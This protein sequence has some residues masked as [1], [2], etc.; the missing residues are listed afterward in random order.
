MPELELL[1]LTEMT[2]VTR[3]V[4]LGVPHIKTKNCTT[5]TAPKVPQNK[6]DKRTQM[7]KNT[8]KI[9]IF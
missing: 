2:V 6:E 7:A 3:I 9:S 1:C 5:A 4:E 8:N